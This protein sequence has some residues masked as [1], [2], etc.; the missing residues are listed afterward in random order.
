[1][2]IRFHIASQILEAEAAPGDGLLELAGRAGFQI[3]LPC[4]KAGRCGSCRVKVSGGT[5]LEDGRRIVAE[6]P[7]WVRSCHT[8][9]VE[10]DLRVEVPLSAV[11]RPKDGAPVEDDASNLFPDG[12]PMTVPMGVPAVGDPPSFGIAADLG[13]TGVTVALLDLRSG[14][15]RG[16]ASG[17]NRQLAVA[18]NVLSRIA[19]T[20]GS[21]ERVAELQKMAVVQSINPLTERLCAT[22]GV[23]LRQI[24][25]CVIAGNTVMAHLAAGE[26]VGAIGQYPFTPPYLELPS[27]TAGEL[28]LAASPEA[29]VWFCP[30]ISGYLGG[31]IS[32]GFLDCAL[33]EAHGCILFIDA[34]TNA[35]ILLRLPDGTIHACSTPAGPALEGCGL[36][37]GSSAVAGAVNHLLPGHDGSQWELSVIGDAPPQSICASAYIELMA[38]IR[39]RGWVDSFG[40][41][42]AD[43]IPPGVG[44]HG[45]AA[46]ANGI[47]VGADLLVE[48]A[49]IALIL[50]AKAAVQ[51][52]I[53]VLLDVAGITAGQIDEVLLAGALGEH[54][55]LAA[56]IRI[57]LFPDLPAARYRRVGNAS[58][59][60][61]VRCLLDAP[62]AR[63]LRER[64][65]RVNVVELKTQDSFND[66]YIDGL[67][68]P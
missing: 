2:R 19:Y 58:L 32:A 6:T 31:D 39:R 64:V 41:L 68:L 11:V 7:M 65:R 33:D 55:D 37:C 16:T 56:A 25:A 21:P 43:R 14:K 50:Q 35:E 9:V 5:V 30:A 4:G 52:G 60:G 22:H 49:D 1:M 44:C 10:G 54:L 27:R 18:D 67:S 36:R 20:A 26:A 38:E 57:G 8:S 45:E 12:L 61:A 46:S 59:K 62:A 23:G 53:A 40:R 29:D 42:Q 48:E 28:G 13:T 63:G 66:L 34:G 15:L 3:N 24:K 51:A 47:R 17:W